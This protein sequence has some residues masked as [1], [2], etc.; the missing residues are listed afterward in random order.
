MN[1]KKNSIAVEPCRNFAIETT[2]AGYYTYNEFWTEE[3]AE[4]IETVFGKQNLI[5]A[6]NCMCHIPDLKST[7]KAVESLLSEDGIFVFEDPSLLNMINNNSYDQ[8]YD[9]HAH[10]F[11]VLALDNILRSVNLEIFKVEN[12]DVHGGSNRIY[13]KK[14][15][16]K[17]FSIGH[18]VEYNKSLEKIMGLDSLEFFIKWGEKIKKSKEELVE[19]F[20]KIKNNGKKI[21]SYGASSKSTTVFNYCGITSRYIDYVID[22][23]PEKQGKL[24]PGT[25]IKIVSPEEGFD[26]TVDFAFLGAWNF[27]QEISKKESSFLKRGKFITHVPTIRII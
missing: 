22:T 20:E 8:L 1:D 10:I 16:S 13:A 4:K 2:D 6:A 24:T 25:H 19:L 11:S 5:Y 12:L 21:I 15:T 7:F 27:A 18:S 23:T 9:E 14:S 3:L 17:R 26:E